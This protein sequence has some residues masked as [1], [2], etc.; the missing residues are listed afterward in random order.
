VAREETPQPESVVELSIGVEPGEEC[1]VHFRDRDGVTGQRLV[2]G[3]GRLELELAGPVKL[4]IG[5]AG[6]ATLTIGDKTFRELGMPG[7]VI[8]TEVT[9]TGFTRLVPGDGDRS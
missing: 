1:W 6:A 9:P 7:Q 2:G 4:T 3:G 8:H 5:N